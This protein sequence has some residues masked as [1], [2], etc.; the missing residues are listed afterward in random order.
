M[1]SSKEKHL[2]VWGTGV[3]TPVTKVWQSSVWSINTYTSLWV[4]AAGLWRVNFLSLFTAIHVYSIQYSM[5]HTQFCHRHAI[6]Y[7]Y[8]FH[9]QQQK[10]IIKKKKE[11]KRSHT[12]CLVTSQF[13][14][15]TVTEHATAMLHMGFSVWMHSEGRKW[16]KSLSAGQAFTRSRHPFMTSFL[17]QPLMQLVTPGVSKNC[18]L[19]TFLGC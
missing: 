15:C 13:H 6:H 2:C 10:I 7:G 1:S 14:T 12:A 5:H 18:H 8:W 4:W 11:K 16:T 17:R 9:Q 3:H 19:P